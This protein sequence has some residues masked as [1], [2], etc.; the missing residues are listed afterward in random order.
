M[1]SDFRPISTS[2]R[3]RTFSSA[4]ASSY[5][6]PLTKRS[7]A[8]LCGAGPPPSH[9]YNMD[10][11]PLPFVVS[12]DFTFTVENDTN[13]HITCPSESLRKRQ[14]T[15]HVVTNVGDG[16]KRHAWVDLVTKGKGVR[17]K[18]AERQRYHPDVD[19]LWQKNAWVDGD[20]MKKLAH[21]FV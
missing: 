11:V 19:M 17:I 20:V 3:I 6:L 13:I 8:M 18:E 15:M 16:D 12:Q 21:K 9:R 4:F 5:F 2:T 14:W 1:A 7:Q 10:Q